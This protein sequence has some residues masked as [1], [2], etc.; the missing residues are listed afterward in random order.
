MGLW[1][2]DGLKRRGR[3]AVDFACRAVVA[4]CSAD[5]AG[6]TARWRCRGPV[7]EKVPGVFLLWN[8]DAERILVEM[9]WLTRYDVRHEANGHRVIGRPDGKCLG[10]GI[11]QDPVYGI[12]ISR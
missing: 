11:Q 6:E 4:S 5:M 8:R 1:K 9:V 10:A 12:Q 2:G 3:G 7:G